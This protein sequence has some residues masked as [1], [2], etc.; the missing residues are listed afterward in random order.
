M[1]EKVRKHEI[2]GLLELYSTD[3]FVF[4]PAELYSI[5]GE[6]REQL[7]NYN[8]YMVARRPRISIKPKSVTL[9]ASAQTIDGIFSVNLG[10]EIKEIPFSYFNF[11]SALITDLGK[12]EYPYDHLRFVVANRT[13]VQIR[14]HDV[15]RF[16]KTSLQPYSDLFVEYVGQSFGEDGDSDAIARLI[17]KTGKQGH[18]SL[19]KVLADIN[20]SNPESEVY[21]LLYSYTLYKKFMIAGG[22]LVPEISLDD[23]PNRFD[24]LLDARVSREER[25]DLIEA[26]L[27]KYFQP[28]YNDT[29][30]KTFP[31]KTHEILNVLFDLDITGLSTSLSTNEHNIR[32]Y[33][34][35]VAP[36]NQ[37]CAR[38]PIVQKSQRASFFDVVFPVA[39]A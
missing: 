38:Y 32:I 31:Q 17:G 11:F 36:S 30:K 27:I 21:L 8:I 1:T 10:F 26:A 22:Y 37:H 35:F 33:S 6:L 29:Y 28:K 2:E 3:P 5:D 18:G 13:P 23:A 20:A 15:I 12:L 25:V 16:S 14:I 39:D 7:R 19:Q 34:K 24:K 9:N 4:R